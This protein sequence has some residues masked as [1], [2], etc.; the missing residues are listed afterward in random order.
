VAMLRGLY[1]GQPAFPFVPGY[2]LVGKI[3]EVGPGVDRSFLGKRVATITETGA[4]SVN[5]IRPVRELVVVPENLDPAEIDTL[6]VNGATAYKMLHRTARVRSADTIVVFG[7]GGGVGTLLVQLAR[8]AGTRVIGTCKPG[9]RAAVQSLGSEVIDYT[10]GNVL[11]QVR[12]LAPEGVNA[13]FDHVGGKDSLRS[14]FAMLRPGGHLICYGG[15][16]GLKGTR[17][18]WW[19]FLEF[20]ALKM[21][22]SLRPGGRKMSFFDVWGRGTFGADRMFRPN[23]FW[24]EFHEDLGRLVELLSAAQLKPRVARRVPLLQASEALAAHKAGGFT[25]KIVLVGPAT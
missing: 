11:A 8:L 4:W 17:S 19:G 14:S 10:S 2:D 6:V 25:G 21:L 9:Q 12:A 20:F 16:S 22:W 7:A 24:R 18:P 23:R 1:P 13:V 5:V 3:I 15:A